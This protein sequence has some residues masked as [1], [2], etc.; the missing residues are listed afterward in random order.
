MAE[1]RLGKNDL[2]AV[3][4]ANPSGAP[5][6]VYKDGG[7]TYVEAPIVVHRGSLFVDQG[8]ARQ[9]SKTNHKRLRDRLGASAAEQVGGG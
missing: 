8:R 9:C 6:A 4:F 5:L 2:L 3:F 7:G 1:H